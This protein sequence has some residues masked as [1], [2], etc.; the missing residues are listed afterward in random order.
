MFFHILKYD[1]LNNIRQKQVIFW[2]MF[3]P[4]ILGTF[5][6]LA[7]GNIYEK[8]SIFKEIPVAVVEVTADETFNTV[9]EQVSTDDFSL[10][11]VKYTNEKEALKLLKES[12]V[13]S[14]I[15]VD[16]NIKL[17][18]ASNGIPETIVKSFI[19]QYKTQKTI[20]TEIAVS[21]PEQLQSVI[22]SL[23]KEISSN[24]DIDFTSNKIDPFGHYFHNLIAM[25]A[26]LGTTCGV[27]SATQNQG[28]LSEIGARKC[29]SPTP[30][31]KSTLSNLLAAYLVQFMCVILCTTYVIYVLKV[32]MGDRIG[33]IYLSGALGTLL[34]ITL[35]FFM[36]AI[37]RMSESVKVG[38]SLMISMFSCFLSGLMVGNMKGV[39]ENYCPIVNRINP[40]SVI[41][42]M[43]YC[44]NLYEDYSRY[45]EKVITLL[46]MSAI[47]TIGGFLLT[48]RKKYASI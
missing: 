33:L 4:I 19:D 21:N 17:S 41:S 15:Y 2:M 12:E 25:V 1:F 30:K 28:N 20:I 44:L 29:I 45:I 31:L 3:F 48:R 22:D 38:L 32:D 8:Q 35:G 10:F 46:V 37:G 5:F 23:S 47:F 40:A 11:K 24:V 42:D 26:L 43:F 14:I 16:E 27:F 36:G 34:G 6:Y 7:F 18:V 9:I 13:S 39:I